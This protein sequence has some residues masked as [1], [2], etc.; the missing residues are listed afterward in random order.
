[1]T[2]SKRKVLVEEIL[3]KLAHAKVRVTTMD[4][5]ETLEVA[6]LGNGEVTCQH[7]LHT[8]LTTDANTNMCRYTLTYNI[9]TN[10][11]Y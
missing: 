2:E 7:S 4:E 3:Q 11:R 9:Y 8:L 10:G 5:Q 1:M 6:E